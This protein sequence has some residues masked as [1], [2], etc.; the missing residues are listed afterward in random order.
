MS[1]IFV[2]HMRAIQA[3]RRL[4]D[5]EDG[6]GE[7]CLWEQNVEPLDNSHVFPTSGG[8]CEGSSLWGNSSEAVSAL[9]SGLNLTVKLI[10]ST[11]IDV[12]ANFLCSKIGLFSS[13]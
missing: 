12:H 2:D 1:V 10:P 13:S 9:G 6:N 8:V 7:L 4:T 11:P 3:S 5:S